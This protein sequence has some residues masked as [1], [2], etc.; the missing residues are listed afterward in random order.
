[1]QQIFCLTLYRALFIYFNFLTY[2][3]TLRIP[4]IF[5]L[6]KDMHIGKLFQSFKEYL[7]MF[8]L[9][10]TQFLNLATAH[11]LQ[12]EGRLC[13]SVCSFFLVKVKPNILHVSI[14]ITTLEF[15]VYSVNYGHIKVMTS[16]CCLS[17][18]KKLYICNFSRNLLM[19]N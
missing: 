7:W 17:G 10:T 12:S 14:F 16:S 9:T 11:T 15:C 5:M 8:I 2:F 4:S 19:I 3:G 6:V 13:P 1:M 18:T